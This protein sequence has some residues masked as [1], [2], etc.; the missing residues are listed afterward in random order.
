L[1][2]VH[3]RGELSLDEAAIMGIVNRTPDSFFDGGRME[4][5]AA[6]AH[7]LKLVAE[8]A[9]ILDIGAVKA[10][11]GEEVS[12]DE[13][14]ARLLP[15]VEALAARTDVPLSIETARPHVARQAIDAGAA[16]INDVSALLDPGLAHVCAETGAALILMHNGGQIRGRP[17]NPRYED[18]TI[19]VRRKLEDLVEMA[20][21]AGVDDERIVIDPGLDF[22]KTTFHSLE[23]LR[24]LSELTDLRWP[25]LVAASRKDV[26]GETLGLPLDERLEGSLAVGVWAVATGAAIIRVHDVSATL[27]AVRMTEA[28]LGTRRPDR[29]VRGLW[30]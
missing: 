1:K 8:G 3:S 6:V 12:E 2:L 17:R 23:L 7:S 19:A 5:D 18:V 9:A 10:G 13:E 30:D 24:R 27:R 21:A 16:M 14:S 11:P 20:R 25:V 29:P 15:L 4:L 28:I 26:V 22:G